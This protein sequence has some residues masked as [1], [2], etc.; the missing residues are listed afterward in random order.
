[1]NDRDLKIT[2]HDLWSWFELLIFSV[3]VSNQ[4]PFILSSSFSSISYN[5]L[6]NSEIMFTIP[7]PETMNSSF[8]FSSLGWKFVHVFSS[9]L[10]LF[11]SDVL[12]LTSRIR[13][14]SS[15]CIAL[16]SYM[17]II[18]SS[19]F[20]FVS[21]LTDVIITTT[22]E[23]IYYFY[24][25]YFISYHFYYFYFFYLI[26]FFDYLT[27]YCRFTFFFLF[28]DKSQLFSSNYSYQFALLR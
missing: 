14:F 26:S 7:C 16:L 11:L 23:F 19:S 21:F 8:I 12:L 5:F 20:S 10:F 3:N 2:Y 18:I 4:L 9:C 27:Y 24:L 15:F 13:F 25:I 17:R 22:A 1:M 6:Q 28:F